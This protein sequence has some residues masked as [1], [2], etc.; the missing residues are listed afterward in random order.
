MK[1]KYLGTGAS[2]GVPSLFCN[3]TVCKKAIEKGGKEIRKRS[4]FL[5]NE[6]LLIDF[7]ADIFSHMVANK[8]DLS[9]I[10]NIFITHSHEDH[11]YIPDLVMRTEADCF[12]RTEKVVRLWGNQKIRDKFNKA[13]EQIGESTCITAG[14]SSGEEITIGDY[15]VKT[16][17]SNHIKGEDCLLYL[18]K[19]NGKTYFHILDSDYPR[20][21]IL[22]Y[23]K[24]NKIKID[25]V[26][27]D[28]TFGNLKEEYNGHMN[29]WQNAKFKA[30]LQE[31]GAIDENTKYVLTHI[32]HYC[33]DTYDSLNETAQK[34]GMI[35]SY[36]GME[37]EL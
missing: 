15:W 4:G 8:I 19:Y 31:I 24:V 16:F 1:I 23:L 14:L 27:A 2:E 29:V 3:C 12:E 7:S 25:C 21:E 10:K 36:D 6:D 32:S 13:I 18:I 11:F 20:E 9:A 35:V 26:S 5:I 22:E 37:I 30:Q 17:Q 28:C 33:K 34:Y